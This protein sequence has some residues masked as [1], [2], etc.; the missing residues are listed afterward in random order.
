M[1]RSSQRTVQLGSF[2][3]LEGRATEGPLPRPVDPSHPSSPALPH[4]ANSVGPGHPFLA[5]QSPPFL[6]PLGFGFPSGQQFQAIRL[7]WSAPCLPRLGPDSFSKMKDSAGAAIDL[8][9]VAQALGSVPTG[10]FGRFIEPKVNPR[11]TPLAAQ[12]RA[13]VPTRPFPRGHGALLSDKV[14]RGA[15]GKPRLV[16]T[17]AFPQRL[18]SL[19]SAKVPRCAAAIRPLPTTDPFS[20]FHGRRREAN[21]LLLAAGSGPLLP[22]WCFGHLREGSSAPIPTLP[23]RQR[24]SGARTAQFP[25]SQVPSGSPTLPFWPDPDPLSFRADDPGQA[26]LPQK[27]M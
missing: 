13:L 3:F 2:R 12:D 8:M 19:F 14:D 22:T 1:S 26:P 18:G 15:F 10:L 9:E 20:G 7:L 11:G 17:R 24:R 6:A 25:R 4:Q 16:P 5:T 21:R 27:T 23:G